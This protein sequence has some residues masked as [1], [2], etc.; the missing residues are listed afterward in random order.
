M[1]LVSVPTRILEA[2]SSYNL[3]LLQVAPF[4][5]ANAPLNPDFLT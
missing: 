1:V 4:L 5:F 2:L 3:D